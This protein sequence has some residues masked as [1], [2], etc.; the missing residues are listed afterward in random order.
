MKP[1]SGT[2]K[3]MKVEITGNGIPIAVLNRVPLNFK[4]LIVLLDA[5]GNEDC[6]LVFDFVKKSRL[7]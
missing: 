7:R 4:N 1:F 6:L 5:L 2:V 3:F